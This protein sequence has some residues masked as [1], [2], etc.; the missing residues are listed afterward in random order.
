MIMGCGL[1]R[2]ADEEQWPMHRC[3]PNADIHHMIAQI[4]T[5]VFWSYSFYNITN[6]DQFLLGERPTCLCK[7]FCVYP[8]HYTRDAPPLLRRHKARPQPS[9]FSPPQH[10]ITPPYTYTYIRQQAAPP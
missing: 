1:W 8:V 4:K 6:P 2:E 7:A 10:R 5:P 9:P 3:N